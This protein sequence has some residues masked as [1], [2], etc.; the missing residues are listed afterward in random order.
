MPGR[1]CLCEAAAVSVPGPSIAVITSLIVFSSL[2]SRFDEGRYDS[3]VCPA[4]VVTKSPPGPN[5]HIGS[6]WLFARLSIL[7][8]VGLL[9]TASK[10][11][12]AL[13]RNHIVSVMLG[14][15]P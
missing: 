2:N 9:I 6:V 5:L 8:P 12:L 10:R 13:L 15:K 14:Q 3:F 4:H 7:S 11:F 1:A